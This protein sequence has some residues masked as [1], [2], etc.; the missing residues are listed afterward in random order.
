MVECTGVYEMLPRKHDVFKYK[1]SFE[2]GEIKS[3]AEVWQSLNKLMKRYKANQYDMLKS[4]CNHFTNDF[5][6]E[7]VG[8]G[9]P[10]HL[11]RVA[12]VLSF[13]HCLVPRR[14]LVVT[15][16]MTDYDVVQSNNDN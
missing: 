15:P 4:N 2:M 3:E 7:L 16:D 13:L 1:H 12:W 5:L 10:R 11:N 8:R 6:T 14:F 9:L